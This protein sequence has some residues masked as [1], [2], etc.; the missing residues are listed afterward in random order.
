MKIVWLV[1][2]TRPLAKQACIIAV[3]TL[4]ATLGRELPADATVLIQDGGAVGS[5]YPLAE[6][7]D[8]SGEAVWFADYDAVKRTLLTLSDGEMAEAGLAEADM[9][10]EIQAMRL[11]RR[12][13]AHWT[14]EQLE[15]LA[16]VLPQL[17]ELALHVDDEDP[18]S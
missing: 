7:I 2:D 3:R 5:Y 8:R 6:A 15:E 4:A 14:E 10:F 11:L 13:F 9:S 12:R 16:G 18:L 1:A 17:F